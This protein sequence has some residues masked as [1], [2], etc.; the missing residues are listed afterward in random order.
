M[1]NDPSVPPPL[2]RPPAAPVPGPEPPPPIPPPA[3]PSSPAMVMDSLLKRPGH[4]VFWSQ[5]DR[6][7]RLFLCLLLLIAGGA[8]VYGVVLGSFAG[9]PQYWRAPVKLALGTMASGLFC[10]PSLY[11]AAALQGRDLHLGQTAAGLFGALAL[12][13]ILLV[14]FAPAA[15]LFSVSTKSVVFMGTLHLFV[16]AIGIA[17]GLRLL[18]LMLG[19]GRSGLR[20]HLAVWCLVFV[21]VCLQMSTTLRP[22]VG[23]SDRFWNPEK[24]FFVAHWW[25]CLNEPDRTRDQPP[26]NRP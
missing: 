25:D 26:Q 12:S 23:S 22:L 19:N 17:A 10:L 15:W 18:R 11:I 9:G 24:K 16:W 4:V 3:E 2:P 7:S 21:L 20:G 1:T 6:R 14:G 8:L 13:G 5:Q